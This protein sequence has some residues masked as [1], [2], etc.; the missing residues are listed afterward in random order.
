MPVSSSVTFARD[1][2]D[3]V[4]KWIEASLSS[5]LLLRHLS[6][7]CIINPIM[8]PTRGFYFSL[9]ISHLNCARRDVTRVR[10]VTFDYF[11]LIPIPGRT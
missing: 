4:E 7:E 1:T 10:D 2:Y 9:I 6:L 3:S 5:R 8:T 11:P